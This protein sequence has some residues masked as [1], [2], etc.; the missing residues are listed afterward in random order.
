MLNLKYY[1]EINKLTL[2]DI[3][4]KYQFTEAVDSIINQQQIKSQWVINK[5]T[6]M[7]D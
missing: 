2:E 6:S 1:K 3:E 4:G 5:A 7:S